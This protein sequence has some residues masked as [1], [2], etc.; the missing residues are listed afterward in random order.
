MEAAWEAALRGEGGSIGPIGPEEGA[1]CIWNKDNVSIEDIWPSASMSAL[2]E[3]MTPDLALQ[4]YQFAE[5]NQHMGIRNPME[6][7]MEAFNRGDIATALLCFEVEAHQ[8]RG[9]SEAWH[10]LGQCH[11]ENDQDRRAILCLE[12]AVEQDPYN[13]NALL[14]L[15]VSYVNELDSGNA[16]RNLKAWIQHNPKYSDLKPELDFY[17]DG[18]LMDEV[19][20]LMLK[21]EQWDADD[22]D[23]KIVLGVLYNVS[24]NY[25][26]AAE[27]FR[28]ALAMAQQNHTVWN[29]LGATLANN[30]RSRE[31]IE[32]YRE[33]LMKRPMYVRGWLNLGISLANLEENEQA[34]K[35]YSRALCLNPKALHIWTYIRIAFTSMKRHDLAQVAASEDMEALCKLYPRVFDGEAPPQSLVH[36]VLGM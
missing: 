3:T 33:V 18:S 20:Q 12:K 9:N 8:S 30:N 14:S 16:L 7:G 21:A 10:M 22:I 25:E 15:G 6:A 35:C 2:P 13:L 5:D 27:V 34:A 28:S 24:Q 36:E 17:S 1:E 11:A 19:M 26:C 32:A 31:A 29:K 4:E 23:A